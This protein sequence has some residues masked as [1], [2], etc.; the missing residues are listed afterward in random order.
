MLVSCYI[1]EL[2]KSLM[3]VNVFRPKPDVTK[4]DSIRCDV[5]EFNVIL[6]RHCS[7]K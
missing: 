3:Y 1:S 4:R 5:L 2:G 6:V 7:M